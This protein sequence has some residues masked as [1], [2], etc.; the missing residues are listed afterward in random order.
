MQ[1][2]LFYQIGRW[3]YNLRWVV[4]I[5][6]LAL[7]VFCLPV[8]PHVVTVFKSTGFSADRSASVQAENFINE[9]LGVGNNKFIILYTSDNLKTSNPEFM[10][11]VEASLSGLEKFPIKHDI[12]YPNVNIKQIAKDKNAAYAA[13]FLKDAGTLTLAQLN[14][15]K[16]SITIPDGMKIEMGGE[17]IFVENVNHQTQVDLFNA[18]Y[19]AAPVS[20]IM[21]LIIFESIIGAIVPI[22][23]G[24]GCALMI[25]TILYFVGSFYTLSIF[26][27]NIALL[28]G[29]CL[30]LDYALFIISRFRYELRNGHGPKTALAITQATAGKAVFFSGLAVFVSLS[31]LLLFPI[32][33][34]ISV[35]VGGLAAVFVAVLTAN[36]VLPA[37]LSVLGPNINLLSIKVLTPLENGRSPFWRRLVTTVVKRPVIFTIAI[38]A[39]L[40]TLSYPMLHAKLGISDYRILP[41]NST[42]RAFFDEYNANFNE[43]TLTP[44]ELIIHTKGDTLSQK[45]LSLLMKATKQITKMDS[46]ESV[47]SIVSIDPTM[48]SKQYYALYHKPPAQMSDDLQTFLSLTTGSD[49]TVMTITSEHKANSAET[50]ELVKDLRNLELADGMSAQVS[51][52][53]ARNMDVFAAIKAHYLLAI[54]T[55]MIFTYLILLILLRSIFLPLKAIA[56]T[57]L[58]LCASYGVLVWIIQDGHL[59]QLLHFEAQGM[60]DVSLLVIIFCALFG[61]SMDYEV[62]LL[63]RIKEH[64]DSTGDTVKSIVTGVE[65]SSRIITSAA[66]IVIVICCSFM[67][68]DVLM[69]KAF[70]LGIAVA[71][72]TDAFLIRSLLVPAVMAIMGKLNWYLPHWLARILPRV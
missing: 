53:T 38:T 45:N 58:S 63:S 18:D 20:I 51:G 65:Y 14:A 43:A 24:A 60:L 8:V 47:L 64:Y 13:V 23:V 71:I 46:V 27:L 44:I 4:V 15:F 72:F 37:I 7:I 49:F 34:L 9:K 59:S 10:N 17:P 69:V 33:I 31:A 35:G 39:M 48:T 12:I 22:V 54:F 30:S 29:L 61:F 41:P 2:E 16:S 32:N 28:L 1:N 57:L 68:A 50:K 62:F 5:T 40:L 11:K 25:L 26:T 6:W 19:I 56:M 55:I 66:L 42:S 70:G 21:M 36:V 67:V 3:L 52:V